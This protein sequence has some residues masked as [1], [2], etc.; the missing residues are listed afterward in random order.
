MELHGIEKRSAAEIHS[1]CSSTTSS[2]HV[3]NSSSHTQMPADA[4]NQANKKDLNIV[5]MQSTGD[6]FSGIF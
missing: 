6:F 4:I 1:G 5:S 3:D 2:V